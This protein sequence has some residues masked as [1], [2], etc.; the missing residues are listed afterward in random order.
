[1][2]AV[3]S[4]NFTPDSEV[5]LV[6][7]L[8]QQQIG[9]E[10]AL[11]L[12]TAVQVTALTGNTTGDTVEETITLTTSTGG[13]K[14]V[15]YLFAE[16]STIP[17]NSTMD[18]YYK[19]PGFGTM[20]Q[21]IVL[22]RN[23][24]GD[25]SAALPS[26]YASLDSVS[27]IQLVV[28]ARTF[29]IQNRDP[30]LKFVDLSNNGAWDTGDP[31]IYDAN[32]NGVYDNGEP[33]LYGS[34]PIIGAPLTVD[35]KIKFV[36]PDN[37]GVWDSGETIVYDT[38]NKGIYDLRDPV[39]YGSFPRQGTPLMRELQRATTASFDQVELFSAT[40]NYDWVRNGNFD[41]GT[42]AGWGENTTFTTSTAV[43]RSPPY[44]AKATVT[45]GAMEMA[46]SIDARPTVESSTKFKASVEVDNLTGN[47]PVDAVDIWL[48][49]VD[50]RGTPVAVY[51][52]F[53]TGNGT[54]PSNTTDTINHRAP[55]F[56]KLGTWLSV[57]ASLLNETVAFDLL[58]YSLPYRL[59]VIVVEGAARSPSTTTAFFD[60]ISVYQPYKP[61]SAPLRV[62]A[63]DGLNSTYTYAAADI[64]YG[65]F[66]IDIPGAQS[67]LNITSPEGVALQPEEYATQ[68]E[69]GLLRITVP[70]ST[71]LKHVPLSTWR[72]Y[73]TS[74]NALSTLYVQDS[75]L[76]IAKTNFNTSA[77]V[78]L[79]S[80]TRDPAGIPQAGASVNLTLFE[81]TNA[82]VVAT[83]SGKADPQGW[84]NIT[85]I[86]LPSK[87][88]NYTLQATAQSA[89]VGVRTYVV[90]V[91]SPPI[92]QQGNPLSEALL[93]LVGGA[94]AALISPVLIAF[95]KRRRHRS[96]GPTGESLK[97]TGSAIGI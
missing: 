92:P 14:Y 50:D 77:L 60:D 96:R 25:A 31:V 93:G 22:D 7:Y 66:Y 6:T 80:R 44:S 12:R 45:S 71:V 19:V 51:Y 78:N 70:A 58:G 54:I 2:L 3:L 36:D 87:P 28:S 43:S 94:S 83:W 33:V 75:T 16:A 29:G 9:F 82:T 62:Y 89:Y 30:H 23:L 24:S 5:S 64:P 4:G 55:G 84:Y 68:P 76:T 35:P 81:T 49:L 53:K 85:G 46:Q 56:G 10:G 86:T 39:I 47:S 37:N 88:G 18:A 95:W 61:G 8:S 42:L 59:E 21:W 17:T 97:P 90:M 27:I 52:Y 1:M 73:A 79:V 63:I 65:S 48:G 15:H 20:G 11:R 57:D 34:T 67:M 26:D 40:G 72:V 41:T 13:T 74:T 32:L 38:N 91:T 69:S